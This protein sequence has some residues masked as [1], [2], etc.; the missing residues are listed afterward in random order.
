MGESKDSEPLDTAGVP[1]GIVG[2]GTMGVGV[3]QCFAAA[4]HPVVVVDP[5]PAARGSGPERI[6]SWTRA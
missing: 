3:A 6:R 5:A 2:A 1:V 4:G